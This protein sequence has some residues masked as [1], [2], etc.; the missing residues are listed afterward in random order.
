MMEKPYERLTDKKA[1]NSYEEMIVFLYA[2]KNTPDHPDHQKAKR[3]IDRLWIK[4]I[5]GFKMPK[6]KVKIVKEKV[7]FS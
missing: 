4:L 1:F 3:I 6:G 5:E 7:I 2:I